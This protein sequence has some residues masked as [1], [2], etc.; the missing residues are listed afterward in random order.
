[1]E[2]LS[3]GDSDVW[4][5]N[6]KAYC[7]GLFVAHQESVAVKNLMYCLLVHQFVFFRL[8]LFQIIEIDVV[9]PNY[10]EVV[11]FDI[12]IQHSHDIKCIKHG[13]D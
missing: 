8:D 3:S 9:L 11:V 4:H 10:S 7:P 1:M 5:A 12:L 2:V 6:R 13:Q